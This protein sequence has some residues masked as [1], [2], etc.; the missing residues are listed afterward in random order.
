MDGT[1]VL[2]NAGELYRLSCV[3]NET[4]T[5]FQISFHADC[6]KSR[7]GELLKHDTD[8]WHTA[9][10]YLGHRSS[11]ALD[12]NQRF[13]FGRVGQLSRYQNR[14]SL[15]IHLPDRSYLKRTLLTL[16]VILSELNYL[17]LV[18]LV[19]L[20]TAHQQVMELTNG[21]RDCPKG[22]GIYGQIFPAAHQAL[23][24]LS[25][26]KMT[27]VIA[28]MQS[29]WKQAAPRELKQYASECGIRIHDDFRPE[30]TCFGFGITSGVAPE[31]TDTCWEISSD[32]V[33][34]PCASLVLLAGWCK[35]AE[36]LSD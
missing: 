22:H 29:V 18:N 14:V 31:H 10:N 25:P 20:N 6:L 17:R 5:Y 26:V 9:Y 23:T 32:N 35:L 30:F 15:E 33:D 19:D 8:T 3:S 1:S 16:H 2:S 12:R 13:G 7:L 4:Q 36:A 28:A 34:D 24:C 11:F 27:E 21:V